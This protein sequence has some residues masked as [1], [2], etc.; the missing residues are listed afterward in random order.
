M[1]NLRTGEID[2][3]HSSFKV[4]FAVVNNYLR[5]KIELRKNASL[6]DIAPTILSLLNVKKPKEMTGS[7]IIKFKK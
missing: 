7:G 6:K 2:T 1:I 3:E 4:P 5:N